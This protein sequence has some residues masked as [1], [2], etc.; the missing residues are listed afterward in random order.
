MPVHTLADVRMPRPDA[1]A[2][3]A[4]MPG[5]S[6]PVI[7]QPFASGDALPFWAWGAFDGNHVYDLR[8]DPGEQRNQAGGALER[9]AAEALRAALQTVEAPPEQLAR[10]G[11][12]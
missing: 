1:R 5:S 2:T 9:D 3:L 8:D 11:L 10:L 7:H 6:V 4:R 12:A